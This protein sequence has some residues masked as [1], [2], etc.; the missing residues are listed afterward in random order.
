MTQT[1]TKSHPLGYYCEP[2][3]RWHWNGTFQAE[4]MRLE[5]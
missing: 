1:T 2:C 4:E 3:D 5:E